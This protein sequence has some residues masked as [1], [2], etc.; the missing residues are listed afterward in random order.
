MN[1]LLKCKIFF[2]FL[3]EHLLFLSMKP[4]S[5]QPEADLPP[6]EDDIYLNLKPIHFSPKRPIH[7]PPKKPLLHPVYIQYPI[8]MIC[9]ML[10]YHRREPLHSVP[11]YRNI[12]SAGLAFGLFQRLQVCI[13]DHNRT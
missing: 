12:T 8:K 1:V 5:C 3:N 7:P 4:P 10:E 11:D 2:D 9:L 6:T 13:F